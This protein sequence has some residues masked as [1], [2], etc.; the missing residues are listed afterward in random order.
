M[1]MD[2][3]VR[4]ARFTAVAKARTV[5][6]LQTAIAT[7]ERS[8]SALTQFVAAEERRTRIVSRSHVTYSLSAKDAADR[9]Y[10]LR[11]TVADLT[12]KLHVAI[13]ERDSAVAHVATLEVMLEKSP[14]SR[15]ENFSVPR[16]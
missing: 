6:D 10:R 9:S 15:S 1:K 12:T 13:I 5:A 7:M 11:K 8:T 14:S 4:R 16:N 3:R 2:E